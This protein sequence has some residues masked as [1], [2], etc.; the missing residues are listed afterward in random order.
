MP[1]VVTREREREREREIIRWT[2][3]MYNVSESACELAFTFFLL[4]LAI[5]F[6]YGSLSLQYIYSVEQH[7]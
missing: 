5:L 3:Y 1:S 6:F 4:F 2:S 7:H